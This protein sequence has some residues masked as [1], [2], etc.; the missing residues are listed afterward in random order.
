MRS[1]VGGRLGAILAAAIVLALSETTPAW[2]QGGLIQPADLQYLGAFRLPEGTNGTGWYYGGNAIAYYPDGDPG[3]DADGYPGSIFGTGNEA[4]LFVSE[5]SIPVPVVSASRSVEE[6]NVAATLQPFTDIFGGLLGYM[7]QPQVGMCYLPAQEGQG[8]GKLHFCIGLHL[9]GTAFEPSHGWFET[10]LASPQT[11]GLWVFGGYTG[12]VTNDYMCEIPRAWADAHVSGQYLATG[13]AREGPWAGGGPGLFAYA[14]W[15]DGNPPTAGTSLS[16]ITPLML[17]GEQIPG[18]PE[19]SFDEGQTIPT[20]TDG[21]R[22]R[23]VA[24]L[25]AGDRAA[26]VFAGTKTVGESWYGFANGVRWPYDCAD[27]TPPTCPQVPDF[28]YANR[29]FWAD[30]FVAQM[31]FFSPDELAAVAR[32][33]AHTSSPRPYAVLDLSPYLLDPDYTVD[34]L[35]N[36]KR[37][38][39]TAMTFDSARG[40]LYLV[41]PVVNGDGETVIHVFRV[42]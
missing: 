36:Y 5:V 31:L 14:P 42:V 27:T 40:L 6:L 29:G 38:F 1:R 24:W 25:T 3:G 18:V 9:Q 26:V 21:D 17:Y 33:A 15:R 16:A 22:F 19:L 41:E 8:S 10:N 32:G 23:A 37:D 39:V 35:I 7:E 13:R 20:H 30:D 12:Y 4:E 11:A 28:P 34:D 2:A